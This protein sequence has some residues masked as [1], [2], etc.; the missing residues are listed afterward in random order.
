MRSFLGPHNRRVSRSVVAVAVVVLLFV[1]GAPRARADRPAPKD[2]TG[3]MATTGTTMPLSPATVRVT[4]IANA[5]QPLAVVQRSG[6]DALYVVEKAGRIRAWKNGAWASAPVL[7]IV[8]R[9]DSVNERGLI[10]LAFPPTRADVLYVDYVDRKGDVNISELPFDGTTADFSRERNLLRIPKPFNE[11]NAGTL[12][13]EP[14]G[15]LL[16]AIGDGGGSG[17]RFNNGQRTDVLLGK[18]LRIDPTPSGSL[19][20]TIPADNPFAKAPTLG[21]KKSRGEVFAY[22]LRNP[23][24]ISVDPATGD[25][26][27]PDVGQNLYEEI[28][29]VP[30]GRAGMNFGWRLREGKQSFTGS[31]PAGATDPVYDYPHKD[32]RCAVVGGAVYRGAKIPGIVGWYVFGDVCTG[33]LSALRQEGASWNPVDLAAKVPYLTA[34]GVGNDDEL[35][36]TSLEGGVYRIDPA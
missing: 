2:P 27:V 18:V 29:R 15:T 12:L 21:A 4:Q 17:D 10:G 6:D 5:D 31:R 36:A 26:W 13:F 7:D 28:N 20:Y 11:H 14:D 9:V 23:W 16:I 19:P 30:K 32:G 22:G 3:Q 1:T 35:Y 34:F 24:R 25:L 8:T 33:R